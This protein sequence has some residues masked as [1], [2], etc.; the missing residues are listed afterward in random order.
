MQGKKYILIV[1]LILFSCCVFG[2][3][4]SLQ[5]SGWVTSKEDWGKV[6]KHRE[7]YKEIK[8]FSTWKITNG[9]AKK[10][11]GIFPPSEK[12]CNVKYVPCIKLNSNELNRLNKNQIRN[13][14]EELTSKLKLKNYEIIEL[15]IE[16]EQGSKIGL[17]LETCLSFIEE[18]KLVNSIKVNF[19]VEPAL[20]YEWTE[21]EW[22]AIDKYI[23]NYILML[24]DYGKNQSKPQNPAPYKSVE[25]DIKMFLKR[26]NKPK[27]INLGVSV[28]GFVWG[29]DGENYKYL[30]SLWM[31]TPLKNYFVPK[32]SISEYVMT[33]EKKNNVLSN[34]FLV[35]TERNLVSW[36]NELKC[37]H[38]DI[39]RKGKRYKVY[40]EDICSYLYKFTLA[41]KYELN[42]ICFWMLGREDNLLYEL[43][44][45]KKLPAILS[46]PKIMTRI[47]FQYFYNKS[48]PRLNGKPILK[49][50]IH[51]VEN[52]NPVFTWKDK[53]LAF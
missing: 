18:L 10:T 39:H 7:F 48:I 35:E 3:I 8:F 9:T 15:D 11:W 22:E 16:R 38:F 31:D 27:K 41:D 25:E 49:S 51:I 1:I 40:Y 43:N 6:S 5:Y 4:F 30:G 13:L 36:E 47:L 26:I 19:V 28:Y 42:G 44:S 29:E 12:S 17:D 24:Y 46:K 50:K 32:Y 37:F 45:F 21:T 20:I 52:K 23:N 2:D 53:S 34:R 33:W 14:V